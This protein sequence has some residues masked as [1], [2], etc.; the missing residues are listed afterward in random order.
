M[1]V[2]REEKKIIPF[3]FVITFKNSFDFDSFWYEH[4]QLNLQLNDIKTVHLA[5][6][7]L[8]SSASN[9]ALLTLSQTMLITPMHTIH[10]RLLSYCI[11]TSNC[12]TSNLASQQSE[13]QHSRL[14]DLGSPAGGSIGNH[15]GSSKN[16]STVWLKHEMQISRTPLISDKIL[17]A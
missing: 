1:H 14:R 11:M 15:L 4:S 17:L 9:A 6:C 12:I 10:V 13:A 8:Y 16:W 2:H 7:Y 5:W 3:T